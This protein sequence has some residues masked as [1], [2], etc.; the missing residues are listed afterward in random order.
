MV[1]KKSQLILFILLVTATSSIF[2]Y[3]SQ[4]F[5]NN[6]YS[7]VLE[8]EPQI[9]DSFSPTRPPATTSTPSPSL[10][11]TPEN[12]PLVTVTATP[13][14]KIS[15]SKSG[16]ITTLSYTSLLPNSIY[17]VNLQGYNYSSLVFAWPKGTT[18]KWATS[19]NALVELPHD[20]D[21]L[22]TDKKDYSGLLPRPD[23]EKIYFSVDKKIENVTI[24]LLAPSQ[25]IPNYSL[26]ANN[27]YNFDA[28]AS[29]SSL[30]V[31]SRD[32]WG[33]NPSTWDGNT[34]ADIDAP[35][36]LI[37][38]PVYYKA[39]RI[40]VHH[41][42]TTPDNNNPAAAVR[43]VYMYHAYVRGWGDIGYNYLIDQNG[44]IYQGKLGGDETMGYH[45][46]GSANQS[47]IGI[48]LIGDFTSTT[49]TAATRT[50]LIR[51]MAE[52]A[53]FFDFSLK[54]SDG[55]HSKWLD[56][57]H[58]VFGHR[59][60][61][62]WDSGSSSWLINS[63]ACPGNA[64]YPQ[65]GG[66]VAEAE[67]Y[68]QNNFAELKQVVSEVNAAFTAP[69]EQGVV[70]VRY[71]VP[72]STAPSVIEGYL[73]KYSGITNYS[74]TGN[75]VTIPITSSLVVHPAYGDSEYLVPPMGWTGYYNEFATL[76]PALVMNGPEDRAK[77]LL[78]IFKLDPRVE[79]ADVKG[80]YQTQ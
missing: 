38:Y 6:G 73:P 61:Y 77:T 39:D 58:T 46:F 21:E 17:E 23:S 60:S 64:F 3:Q 36:R 65:L 9:V 24:S 26:Q 7:E 19:K 20:E 33:A 44:T 14:P 42:V 4:K 76:S 52:K 29:Y 22:P 40:V 2:V 18:V 1:S 37:W 63:T 48:S 50:A 15:A 5:P 79:A 32:T 55:S 51:L 47:S 56:R 31:V 13:K 34:S 41:T 67:T 49:P 12:T 70:V 68:R 45:A 35:S 62:K 72:E 78:K 66:L 25:D 28:G 11:D 75:T 27:V 59:G 80:Y 30:P 69:H 57:S 54:F 8:Q 74:I 71:A 10:L 43:G 16:T 53:V